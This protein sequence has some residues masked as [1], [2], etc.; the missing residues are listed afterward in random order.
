MEEPATLMNLLLFSDLHADAAAARQLMERASG[1]V[2]A[3]DFGNVCRHLHQC[4][5]IHASAGQQAYIGPTPI[6]NTSSD[7]FEWVLERSI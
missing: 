5:H 3:G 2:G 1:F 6:V 7:G 4:G